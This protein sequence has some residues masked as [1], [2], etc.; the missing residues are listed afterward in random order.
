MKTN[1]VAGQRATFKTSRGLVYGKILYLYSNRPW[2]RFEPDLGSTYAG[3]ALTTL[4]A[5]V[6]QL[7]PTAVVFQPVAL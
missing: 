3:G 1:L 4:D 2:A 6:G 7:E 5:D